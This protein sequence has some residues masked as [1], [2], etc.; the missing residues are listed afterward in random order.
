MKVLV[1]G[2]AGFIG[3]HIADALLAANHDVLVLDDVST[4]RRNNVPARANFVQ[5]DIRDAE[6]VAKVF[7]DFQ[8][9]VVTHQAAQTSVA[10]SARE[11]LRDAD[12]NILGSL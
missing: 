9:N 2:G 4:G 10:V 1:T 12:V 11:P 6:L 3:S 5:G 8:P 7:A